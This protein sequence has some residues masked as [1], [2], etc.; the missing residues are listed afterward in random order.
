MLALKWS[1]GLLSLQKGQFK[2]DRMPKLRIFF[3]NSQ[4]FTSVFNFQF[5]LENESDCKTL[6]KTVRLLWD[7]SSDRPLTYCK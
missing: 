7:G 2:K 6:P 3:Q 5:W 1:G 4:N